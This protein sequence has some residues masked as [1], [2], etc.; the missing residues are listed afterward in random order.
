MAPRFLAQTTEKIE[1]PST[2]M[3]AIC[4]WSICWEEESGI[5]SYGIHNVSQHVQYIEDIPH[6]SAYVE[7]VV[8]YPSAGVK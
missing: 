8:K 5:P 7:K 3:R 2:E 6:I 4:E 1:L